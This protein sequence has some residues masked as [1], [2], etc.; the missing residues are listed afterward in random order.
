[1]RLGSTVVAIAL[2][3]QQL[4]QAAARSSRCASGAAAEPA[5]EHR[6]GE[7]AAPAFVEQVGDRRQ[8]ENIVADRHARPAAALG[9][10]EDSERQVLD[11]EVAARLRSQPS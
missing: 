9:L 2:V 8:V 1:M 10:G 5:V 11:R 7:V 6:L 4:G 3:G